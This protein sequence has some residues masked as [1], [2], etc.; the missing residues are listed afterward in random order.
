ML[1]S[2]NFAPSPDLAPFVRQHFVFR[3]PLPDD[4]VLIDQLLSETAM[5]RLLLRGDWAAQYRTEDWRSEGPALLFGHNSR[6]FRVRV[7][8]AF[9][10]VGMSIRP[11][12]W[13]ALF[14]CKAFELTD[15]MW[16]LDDLWGDAMAAR[17]YESVAA[18]ADD[19]VAIVA[20]IEAIV[21][22]RLS[23]VG[24]YAVDPHMAAFEEI[25]RDDST[26]R[27]SDAGAVVGLSA[28]ALERHCCATFGMT[29]KAVLRRSRFL[30]MAAALRGMSQ[31][32]E[33]EQAALRFSDQ[34]HLN[35]EFR[36]FVGLTPGAFEKTATPLLN[37]VLQLRVAGLS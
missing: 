3:A 26:M 4:V 9:T 31:P 34:S 7:K 6:A 12:G 19:D 2:R 20:A 10:V 11:S 29:P 15:N 25:V 8:G 21:R 35:R 16:L 22:E 33:E 1:Q 37:A 32:D 30:D 18:G 27:V 23:A 28:R 24:T 14:D 5:V 36:H 17:L 13:P